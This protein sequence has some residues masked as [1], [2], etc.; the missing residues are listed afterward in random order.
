MAQL[1]VQEGQTVEV[2]TVLAV[3][4]PAGA[5]E[6]APE[7]PEPALP[8]RPHRSTAVPPPI[9]EAPA[10][11]PAAEPSAGSATPS[12]GDHGR[13]FVSPVVARIAAEHGV[14]PSV[15]PG[16]GQGGR[17]T[18]KDILRSSSPAATPP[19][20]GALAPQVPEEPPV[21][22]PPAAV[23]T[24]CAGARGTGRRSGARLGRRT[25]STGASPFRSSGTSGG[26]APAPGRDRGADDGDAS[27]RDGPHAPVA[28]HVR[29]RDQRDRGRHVARRRRPRVA[30]SGVPALLR[31]QPHVPRVRG[32]GDGG[33]AQGLA[34]D[35][36]RAAR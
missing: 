19:P 16:T 6:P 3:I 31:G 9:A 28:R 18:K 30:Q 24:C 36:R 10:P 13:T 34:V 35:Q 22:A 2:G 11:A 15:I 12:N 5:P 23:G 27:R 8:S 26:S 7:A 29:A 20:V 4:A 33:D 25:G 17:V 14:D 1:L 21:A 32:A